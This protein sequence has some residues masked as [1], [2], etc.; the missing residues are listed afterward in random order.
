MKKNFLLTAL[1]AAASVL[2]ASA[3]VLTPYTEQ[4]EN[5]TERPKGWLRGGA[6]SYSQG[7]YKVVETGGHS[8]GYIIIFPVPD[9]HN[10]RY[11]A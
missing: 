1:V 3:E 7:T 8:D 9:W 4:F 2:S 10:H 5:P 6:S 11:S